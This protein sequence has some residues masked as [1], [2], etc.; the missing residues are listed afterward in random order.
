MSNRISPLHLVL[1]LLTALV[2]AWSAIAG[3][4]IARAD[5]MIAAIRLAVAL[6]GRAPQKDE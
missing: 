2:F 5:S 4:N 1:L 6:A 3:Q